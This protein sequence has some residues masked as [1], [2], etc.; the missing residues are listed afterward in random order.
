MTIPSH[1]DIMKDIFQTYLISN[2]VWVI[3][4]SRIFFFLYIIV[5]N[6]SRE[7]FKIIIIEGELLEMT[8]TIIPEFMCL[9]KVLSNKTNSLAELYDLCSHK[10]I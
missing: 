9:Y 2:Q 5:I 6:I 4:L 3:W 7:I 1:N 10:V 8:M